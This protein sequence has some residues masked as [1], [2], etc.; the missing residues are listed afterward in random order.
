MNLTSKN[1]LLRELRETDMALFNKLI[2]SQEVEHNVV[3]WSKPVTM[4][5]Q[6]LWY[7]NI[8]NDSNIRYTIAN[9]SDDEVYGTLII[10][11]SDW[12][13]RTCGLDIKVLSEYRGRGIGFESTALAIDYIFNE[14]N[15]HRITISIL[16]TNVSSQKL[17][18][19]VG[20]VKEG[21]QRK[22]VFKNGKYCDLFLYGL[23]KED[24]YNE[25]NR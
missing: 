1:I 11:K 25:R 16:Q 6:N 7:Q 14:L 2:N 5:E 4:N 22:A 8:K 9:V 24:F 12:K 15:L 21:I 19:K 23:L 20:F 13:N 10:S 18:E 3:G 17:F